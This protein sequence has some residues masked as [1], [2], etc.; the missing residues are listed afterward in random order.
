MPMTQHL[1][2]TLPPP[3]QI[4]GDNFEMWVEQQIWGHRIYNDQ[5]PWLLLLE[6]LAIM[7]FRHADG[8]HARIFPGLPDTAHEHF[9]YRL[10]PRLALR[11]IVFRDRHIDEVAAEGH[12]SDEAAWRTWLDRVRPMSSTSPGYGEIRNRFTQFARFRDAVTLLRSAE[13]ESA[14]SRR[15]TSR[16]FAPRGPDMLCADV[17][18]NRRGGL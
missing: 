9:C 18:L 10:H 7:G 5:T 12:V 6:A 8:N 1:P 3:P 4:V 11:D 17:G 15:T 16:H 2:G 14:R 13:I